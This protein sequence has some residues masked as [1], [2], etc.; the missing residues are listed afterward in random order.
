MMSS[1][2]SFKVSTRPFVPTTRPARLA[3]AA[4]LTVSLFAGAAPAVAVEEAG[5]TVSEGVCDCAWGPEPAP[6]PGFEL[7]DLASRWTPEQGIRSGTFRQMVPGLVVMEGFFDLRQ[8]QIALTVAPYSMETGHGDQVAVP[9]VYDDV[10]SDLGAVRVADARALLGEAGDGH[11]LFTLSVDGTPV[12]AALYDEAAGTPEGNR[13]PSAGL[14]YA[15]GEH[16]LAD[17]VFGDYPERF[18]TLEHAESGVLLPFRSEGLGDD[19]AVAELS[20]GPRWGALWRDTTVDSFTGF[21]YLADATYPT[22][23]RLVLDWSLDGMTKS[24]DVIITQDAARSDVFALVELLADGQKPRALNVPAGEDAPSPGEA[25]PVPPAEQEP[26]DTPAPVAGEEP[27]E[28]TGGEET[29]TT[30]DTVETGREVP[31]GALG[32]LAA[33]GAGLVLMARGRVRRV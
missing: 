33:L 22:D 13:G 8:D 21:H 7:P 2:S 26:V 4:I 30:P 5:P 28:G 12:A 29:H 17:P 18:L 15:W 1:P 14:V 24:E 9:L 25:D 27:G 20:W 19:A 23:D 31:A 11:L 6:G 32:A 3:A 16:S 10:Y